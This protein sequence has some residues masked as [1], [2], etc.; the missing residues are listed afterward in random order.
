M[1]EGYLPET[2]LRVFIEHERLDTRLRQAMQQQVG[3]GQVG[4]G[5]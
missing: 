1:N 4:R 2:A 5:A 3:L